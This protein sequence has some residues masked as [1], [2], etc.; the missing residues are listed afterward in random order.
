MKKLEQE[1]VIK[2]FIEK[3]GDKYDYSQVK[4]NGMNNPVIVICPIHGAFPVTPSNHINGTGCPECV[5]KK[6]TTER[7]I[8]EARKVHGD[9]Y[10]YSKTEYK[11]TR[12]KICIISHEK[13]KDGKEIGEFWQYPMSHIKGEK[14]HKEHHGYKKEDAWE[15]RICPV[16]G[17]SFEVRK[18]YKKI[19]CSEECR[20]IYVDE[21]KDE[22]NKKR[23]ESVKKTFAKKTKEDWERATEKLKKTCLAKYGKENYSQTEE[24]RKKCSQNMKLL[25]HEH[26]EKYKSEILIPKYREI[27]EKDGLELIDFRSRFDCNVKC[28]KCGNVFNVKV[29]G[30]LT[31]GT[32]SNLCRVCHPVEPITGPTEFENSFE[33]FIK[34]LGIKYIKNSRTIIYP[35]E[36]DFYFPDKKVGFELDGLY[37][38]CE[39]QKP[40]N[41]HLEKTEKC[42]SKGIRLI[43]I[44]EDEWRDKREIC[45]SRIKNILK[46]ESIKI[47]ARK[48]EVRQVNKNEEKSFLNKNHIQGYVS[49]KYCYGLFY[50]NELVSIM[51][52][53][54]LRKNL[55]SKNIEG[56]FELLRFCNKNGVNVQG[57]A[58][59]LLKH[60]ILEIKPNKII[61]YADRRWSQGNMY[62]KLGLTFIHNT[63]P[64]YFYLIGGN[65]K[66]RFGFRKNVLIKKYNCP[67]E[68]SEHEFC[69]SQHWYRIYDCGSKLYSMEI[70]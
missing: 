38:H 29:L 63:E 68:M 52:F 39:E 12:H 35:K 43:H 47:G 67:K 4:Y 13:D 9:R 15:T 61:S 19:C 51:S 44:F 40:N 22:I 28:K 58:S 46:A 3:H 37:W 65:R 49:S 11:G 17:N 1:E 18:K 70:K 2:K 54:L 66:N 24:G 21:H 5:R 62:E 14:P 48:C 25:K 27:C 69:L 34:T 26:D 33:S 6:W 42:L 50:N 7:I 23:G 57:G 45:M 30:Y 64:N 36:V 41:Y 55:G 8:E 10:D 56:C 20:H 16:C 60:F 32:N 31:P 53:C 59:R